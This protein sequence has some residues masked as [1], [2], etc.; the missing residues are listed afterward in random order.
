MA[1]EF[2]L[3][4]R[5]HLIK[6]L[7]HYYSTVKYTHT[8]RDNYADINHY[9]QKYYAFDSRNLEICPDNNAITNWT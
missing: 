7:F 6:L 4:R 2:A 9:L 1:A 8:G 3:I 5:N